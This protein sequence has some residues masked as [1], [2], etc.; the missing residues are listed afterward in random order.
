MNFIYGVHRFLINLVG[1]SPSPSAGVGRTG[2]LLAIDLALEQ[3]R[4]E[5]RVDIPSVVS[6]LRRQRMKMVQS[7]VSHLHSVEPLVNYCLN[8]LG[9][10]PHLNGSSLD[11]SLRT[12]V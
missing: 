9:T 8:Q 2:S 10:M 4:R 7:Q 6:S 11:G 5:G 12:S 1:I 3:A